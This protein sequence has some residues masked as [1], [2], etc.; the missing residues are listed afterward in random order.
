MTLINSTTIRTKFN[1]KVTS[2]QIDKFDRLSD[3]K[4]AR[5]LLPKEAKEYENIFEAMSAYKGNNKQKLQRIE[6]T[7]T[8]KKMQK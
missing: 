1:M 7:L 5:N 2:A 8:K 4:R 3:I 6:T